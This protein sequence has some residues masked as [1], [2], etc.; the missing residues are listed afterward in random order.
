MRHGWSSSSVACQSTETTFGEVISFPLRDELHPGVMNCTKLPRP[1]ICTEYMAR[2]NGSTFDGVLPIAKKYNVGA[3]NW[4]LVVGKTQT[5]LPWDSWEKPYVLSQPQIWFHEVFYGDGR[6]YR[7]HEVE[8]I[9]ELTG[10]GV[11]EMV[12]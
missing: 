5:N 10:R 7:E 9:R 4:G 2:G 8:L 1:L 6:P 12:H 11:R 3:I